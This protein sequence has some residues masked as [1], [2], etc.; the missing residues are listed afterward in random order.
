MLKPV[1]HD[2]FN[3]KK[4]VLGQFLQFLVNK[5]VH[6]I[7]LQLFKKQRQDTR[8]TI[9]IMNSSYLKLSIF[10]LANLASIKLRRAARN[11]GSPERD[12]DLEF[13]TVLA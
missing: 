4:T 5:L 8:V 12:T 9:P 1:I 7:H 10:F 11:S 2:L 6:T 13:A 3:T